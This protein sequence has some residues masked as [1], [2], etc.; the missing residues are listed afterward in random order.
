MKLAQCKKIAIIVCRSAAEYQYILLSRL[1]MKAKEYG[2]YALVYSCFDKYGANDAYDRGEALIADLPDFSQMD[3]VVIA[4]DTF[5]I[6]EVADKIVQLIRDHATCP[7]VSVRRKI[8][9]FCNV[10][11]DDE[12]SMVDIMEHM[13][14]EHGVRDFCYVSG[15]KD[16]PDAVNRLRCFRKVLTRHQIDISEND[17]YHG[18][19]WR[20]CGPD[21]VSHLLEGRAGIPEAI[22]CANDYMA[23][24]VINE[25]QRLGYRVPDDIAVTGFDDI[26][27]T[28]ATAPTLTSVRVDVREMA[29]RAID[30]IR[31][32]GEGEKVP[33]VTFVQTHV[34]ARE[35][36][37][38]GR[39]NEEQLA[40]AVRRYFEAEQENGFFMLQ[41]MFMGINCER[42]TDIDELNS[43]IY[44]FFN[45]NNGARDFY[46]VLNDYD[47][48]EQEAEDFSGFT[49]MVHLRTAIRENRLLGHVDHAFELGEILPEEYIC[50]EPCGYY[51]VPLHYHEACLGY[52]VI[53][54]NDDAVPNLF[55]QPFISNICS[56]L[57]EIRSNMKK[58]T[59]IKELQHLYVSDV[60]TGLSNRRGFEQKSVSMYETARRKK[61]PMAI[62]GIDMD[63]LKDINDTFGHSFG[64]LALKAI[65]NAMSAACYNNEFCYRVG[66]DEFEVLALNYTEE[67]VEEYINRFKAFLTDFNNR[68]GRPYIV[69]AS[70]GYVVT[71]PSLGRTLGE[72]MTI[73]D[74]RMYEEKNAR[75][76]TRKIIR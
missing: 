53:T 9:G 74:D 15:P 52:A 10:L 62:I 46:I 67:M 27:E 69:Q 40:R 7:V 75:R 33:D 34:V 54:Y 70:I 72:W 38:C 49:P 28:E 11:V 59:L 37:G 63:G 8:D 23:I 1:I 12:N 65:A 41:T 57:E 42:A 16:H 44:E 64:D 13:I 30:A 73:S 32:L 26:S 6:H 43:V 36:C 20:D 3:G 31:L 19:F 35:S 61:Q 39:R 22:V 55:F 50:E 47:W 56:A 14:Q 17:I 2:Y 4:A 25:L 18:D 45:R 71:D 24:S 29:D 21:A 58:E 68:S 76:K 48:K 66:G 5:E 60:M 51:I